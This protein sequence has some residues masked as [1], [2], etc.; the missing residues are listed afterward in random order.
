MLFS[1]LY[2]IYLFVMFTPVCIFIYTSVS[3]LINS[4][5]QSHENG[6][7]ILLSVQVLIIFLS[8]NFLCDFYTPPDFLFPK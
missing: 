7:L 2:Y 8:A 6:F 5:W 4:I 1:I 3:L